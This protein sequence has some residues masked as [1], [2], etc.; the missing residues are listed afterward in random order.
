MARVK[1]ATAKPT[2]RQRAA[3]TRRRMLDAAIAC[4]T[5]DGYDGTT[6]AQIAER[7]GVAVQTL[8]FT[9]HT[10]A[11]LLQQT[12]D[13]A[14]L[15]D[16]PPVPPPQTPWYQAMAAQPA[17]RP[18][19]EHLVSGVSQILQRVAPLR[20][21]FDAAAA[22]PGV[23]EVWANAEQLRLDGYGAI[24]GLLASKQPL[25]PGY[26]LA[27]ATDVL[28]VLLGPDTFRAFTHGRGW[29]LSQW[30]AWVTTTLERDLFTPPAPGPAPSRYK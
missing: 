11:E 16:G 9:F 5:T 13:R 27:S 14:V 23:A 10:K 6:M 20:P 15:G 1:P 22:E 7:A 25:A 28:F 17:I 3:E 18:A 21:V 19:L 4:F 24:I 8:Y 2:R 30:N 12:L 26:T 29:P